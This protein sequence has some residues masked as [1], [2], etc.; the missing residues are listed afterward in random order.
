MAL[1]VRRSLPNQ[2][3]NRPLPALFQS[4]AAC[5]A[6][7]AANKSNDQGRSISNASQAAREGAT[8]RIICLLLRAPAGIG[9]SQ[10]RAPCELR[11]MT[12]HR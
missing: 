1:M 2:A 11:P 12:R 10:R 8:L 9:N 5:S 6:N 7:P 4:H 3:G